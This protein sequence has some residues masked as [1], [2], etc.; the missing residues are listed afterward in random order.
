[1]NLIKNVQIPFKLLRL[2]YYL[3]LKCPKDIPFFFDW[4]MSL[5]N[6]K[7][8]R[9]IFVDQ[10]PWLTYRATKWL[11]SYLKP[12]MRVFEYGSGG[13]TLF[14][15]KRVKQVVSVEH[16]PEWFY[17]IEK[18]LRQME[19]SNVEYFLREPEE[20]EQ[21]HKTDSIDPYSYTSR[22][23]NKFNQMSFYKYVIMM[24]NYPDEYF[25]LVLID[26]RARPS[27]IMHAVKKVKDNG[28]IIL[29]NSER[30]RYKPAIIE[31]LSNYKS[32]C[33]F[34]IGS[35]NAKPWETKIFIK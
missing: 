7:N 30:A 9:N 11:G 34:G 3:F 24:E 33:F 15:A 19:I 23:Q 29:D 6:N 17:L 4:I 10:T 32:I 2:T 14:F 12:S 16:N 27:C 25:D 31:Y 20:M 1:M 26:G 28:V 21:E 5:R 18:I 22:F 8:Y 13:S 35:Y